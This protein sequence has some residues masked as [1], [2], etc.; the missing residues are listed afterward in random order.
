[1]RFQRS[2]ELSKRQLGRDGEGYLGGCSIVPL[3]SGL[4]IHTQNLLSN[5]CRTAS[6]HHPTSVWVVVRIDRSAQ[7]KKL[8]ITT[9]SAGARAYN[10]GLRAELGVVISSDLSLE[11]HASSLQCQRHWFPPYSSTSTYPVISQQ[12]LCCDTRSRIRDVP[13]RLL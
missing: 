11:K 10:G 9:A 8:D 13:S 12:G 6:E 3:C 2:A 1:M 4:W 5:H 7:G